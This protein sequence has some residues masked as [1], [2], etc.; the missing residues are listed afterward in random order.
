MIDPG[1][2]PNKLLLISWTF[3]LRQLDFFFEKFCFVFFFFST[4]SC[5]LCYFC[6]LIC[7][8]SWFSVSG[9]FSPNFLKFLSFSCSSKVTLLLPY[10]FSAVKLVVVYCWNN[11]RLHLTMFKGSIDW[12]LHSSGSV[13]GGKRSAWLCSL[14]S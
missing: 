11:Y 1:V 13:L 6:F 8:F 10:Q 5:S 2:F 14:F 3:L 9:N 12:F 7:F 4:F